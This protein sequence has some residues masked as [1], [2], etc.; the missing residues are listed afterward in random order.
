MIKKFRSLIIA[1]CISLI[2]MQALSQPKF[3]VKQVKAGFITNFIAFTRWPENQL[4][5]QKKYFLLC[6]AGKD[7]YSDI[8]KQYPNSGI[9]GRSLEVKYLTRNVLKEDI[10]SC[11][12]LIIL[13]ENPKAISK[14]LNKVANLPVLTISEINNYQSQKTMINLDNKNNR[15]VFSVN[16]QLAKQVGLSF[17]SGLLR[18]AYKVS[19]EE[20]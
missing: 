13:L 4:T 18:L 16:R 17:S 6:A 9:H 1:C 19:G 2:S 14:L 12:V 10:K 3:D 5:P 15:L 8:F 20:G 11:D 7:P